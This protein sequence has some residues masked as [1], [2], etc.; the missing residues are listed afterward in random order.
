MGPGNDSV[1]VTP[2]RGGFFTDG[3]IWLI[4]IAVVATIAWGSA[5]SLSSGRLSARAWGTLVAVGISQGSVYALLALGYSMVYGTLGF[6]NLAHGDMLMVGAI[7]AWL[8]GGAL[9]YAGW[10]QAQPGP[11]L[12]LLLVVAAA[13]GAAA[14]V[15]LERVA[16]RPIRSSPRLVLLVT[17]LGASLVIQYSVAGLFG[18]AAKRFPDVPALQTPVALGPVRVP[19]S[20]VLVLGAALTM[21]AGLYALVWHTRTGRSMRA[22]GED[23]GAAALMGVDVDRAV[24]TVFAVGGAAAGAAGLLW[25]ILYPL[26]HFQTGFMPGIKAF[27]AAVLGGIG[28][29]PGAVLG[30]YVLGMAESIGPS[31]VLTGLGI[32]GAWQLKDVVGISVL[33]LALVFRPTGLLGERLG[34]GEE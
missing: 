25:A 33:V 27:A 11:S 20:Q 9:W 26:V 13:T 24:A 8:A 31:L 23:L 3:I 21:L 1:R 29:L 15:L 7:S 22:A 34:R 10:W 32:P 30:G 17:S 28:N 18:V 6:I 5:V 4:R 12:L 14:S 2:R 19:W 16:F